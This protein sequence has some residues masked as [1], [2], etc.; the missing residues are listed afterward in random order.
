MMTANLSQ[1]TSTTLCAAAFRS[2]AAL[3]PGK[4]GVGCRLDLVVLPLGE[5]DREQFVRAKRFV[6]LDIQFVSHTE[7]EHPDLCEVWDEP[8]ISKKRRTV[9][10]PKDL[11]SYVAHLYATPLLSAA[12]EAYLFRRMNYLKFSAAKLQKKARQ[13][14]IRLHELDQAEAALQEAADLRQR[15]IEANLRLVVSIARGLVS[16]N[17]EEFDEALANGNMALVRAVD[18]FDFGKGFRFSTYAYRAISR[19][20]VAMLQ[21]DHRSGQ[22]VMVDGG[23]AAESLVRDD[24]EPHRLEEEAL[25][26]CEFV[27]ELVRQLSP[28]EQHVVKARFGLAGTAHE[29]GQTLSAIGAELGL[30]KERVRQL[31]VKAL[32]K[33]RLAAE[34]ARRPS[35]Q[36]T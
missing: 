11:P 33:L 16:P 23:Q 8:A 26:T 28:R 27:E 15:L 24:A 20:V 12:E 9:A 35:S 4:A 13:K 18:L 1:R 2:R 5:E 21:S 7:F 10:P 6:E 32:R 31:Q 14:G 3:P 34:E 19:A 17:T 22:R 36:R 29:E 30:S 25:Q